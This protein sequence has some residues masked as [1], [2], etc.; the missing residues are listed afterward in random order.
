MIDNFTKKKGKFQF[1]LV[2]NEQFMLIGEEN[3]QS[4]L[5][6]EE[7]EHSRPIGEEN[8]CYKMESDLVGKKIEHSKMESDPWSV[9]NLSQPLSQPQNSI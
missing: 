2:K 4:R 8:E 9:K 3:E 6:G 5:I 1:G 7:N